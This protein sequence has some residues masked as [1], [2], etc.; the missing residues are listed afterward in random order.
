MTVLV[1]NGLVFA[2][3]L[4][5]GLHQEA[6]NPSTASP[7]PRVRIQLLQVDANPPMLPMEMEGSC[8]HVMPGAA[9]KIIL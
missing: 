2:D 4:T 8:V 5:A 3:A 1:P 6:S 9:Y 7:D